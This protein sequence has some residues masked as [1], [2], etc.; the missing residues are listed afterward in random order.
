MKDEGDKSQ[1]DEMFD[2]LAKEDNFYNQTGGSGNQNLN[3]N[4]IEKQILK[5]L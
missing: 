1:E 2:Y 5:D 4:E 3:E